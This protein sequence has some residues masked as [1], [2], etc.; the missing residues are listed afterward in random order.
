MKPNTQLNNI[1]SLAM[2]RNIKLDIDCYTQ[3]V[4]VHQLGEVMGSYIADRLGMEAIADHLA[5]TTETT[6]VTEG[7]KDDP[8]VWVKED[9]M[10]EEVFTLHAHHQTSEVAEGIKAS[11]TATVD[12]GKA[13]MGEVDAI[14]ATVDQPRMN[15]GRTDNEVLLDITAPGTLVNRKAASPS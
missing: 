9:L 10:G 12:A 5:L 14:S 1:I 2:G 6:E 15:R 4:T 8:L 7:I 13:W 3:Q 11:A